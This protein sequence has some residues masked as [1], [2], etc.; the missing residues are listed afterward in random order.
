ML[1]ILQIYFTKTIHNDIKIM[2]FIETIQILFDELTEETN[3]FYSK[4]QEIPFINDLLEHI[5]NLISINSSSCF[6]QPVLPSLNKI[7]SVIYGFIDPKFLSYLYNFATQ[8]ISKKKQ[9]DIEGVQCP[10]D[11]LSEDRLSL[12]QA[13]EIILLLCFQALYDHDY[14]S[15]SFLLPYCLNYQSN[16]NL[17]IRILD[18]KIYLYLEELPLP[19]PISYQYLNNFFSHICLNKSQYYL[20][21]R[22]HD[23]ENI[24]NLLSQSFRVYRRDI[25]LCQRFIYLLLLFMKM[26]YQTIHEKLCSNENW[27]H[28]KKII[29][30]FWQMTIN[31]NNLLNSYMRK[32]IIEIKELLI[33]NGEQLS[34]DEIQLILNDSSYSVRLQANKICLN[35]FFENNSIDSQNQYE[36]TDEHDDRFSLGIFLGYKKISPSFK[37]SNQT[38]LKSSEQ[39]NKIYKTLIEKNTLSILM[40]YHLSNT[41]ECLSRQV[42]FYLIEFGK[43]NTISKNIIKYLLRN[44]P[45]ESIIQYW[46]QQTSYKIKDFPWNFLNINS[47]EEYN[48]FLFSIYFL[49]TTNNRQQLNSLFP[50]IKSSVIEYFPQIQTNILPLLANKMKDYKQAEDNRQL[51][52]KIISKTEYNR[53]MKQKLTMI[54]LHLLLTYSNDQENEYY[55]KW[56]PEPILPAYNWSSIKITFDYIKQIMNVKSFSELLIK[57]TVSKIYLFK[58]N[59]R[60]KTKFF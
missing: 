48:S 52:E 19:D 21:I 55:D 23:F 44:V 15:N 31:K 41:S 58:L 8:E 38:Y 7:P 33:I 37:I 39:Q 13:F 20:N 22:L 57:S 24:T 50:D 42:A 12:I 14:Y 40:L 47:I 45:I 51:V 4:H 53:L 34:F 49:S 59:S 2:T 54:I 27:L 46:H 6:L 60:L 26:F 56:L 11:N 29:D 30:A 10:N 43:K 36:T 35:L 32:L 17:L 28:I 1:H 3:F 25:L 16:I 18:E 9:F 5:K